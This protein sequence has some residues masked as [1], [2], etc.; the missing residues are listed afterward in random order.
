MFVIVI[1]V[2]CDCWP[3]PHAD[4]ET[5]PLDS[6]CPFIWNATRCSLQNKHLHTAVN[7]SRQWRL[8][9]DACWAPVLAAGGAALSNTC[10]QQLLYQTPSVFLFGCLLTKKK[11]PEV[12]SR[13]LSF[14]LFITEY[15]IILADAEISC[16]VP[17]SRG[18][19]CVNTT[20]S[21][22]RFVCNKWTVPG[23]LVSYRRGHQRTIRFMRKT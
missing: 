19:I 1:D 8:K 2:R 4:A 22:A 9:W 17:C 21:M 3:K 12:L 15:S 6:Y 7:Q 16:A 11:K 10:W 18:H 23:R 5:R 13:K 14:I 20:P